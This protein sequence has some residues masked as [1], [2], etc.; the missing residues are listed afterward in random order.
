MV[1]WV[2][3]RCDGRQVGAGALWFVMVQYSVQYST[4][5]ERLGR[6]GL[7]AWVGELLEGE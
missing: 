1:G 4:S 2:V 3:V 6:V 7:V 5:T